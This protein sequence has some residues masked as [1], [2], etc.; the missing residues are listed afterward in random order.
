VSQI[1]TKL[2]QCSAAEAGT[3]ATEGGGFYPTLNWVGG[4]LDAAREDRG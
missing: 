2:A 3:V 4:V 1:G